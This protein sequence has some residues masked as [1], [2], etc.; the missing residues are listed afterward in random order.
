MRPTSI[1][2]FEGLSLLAVAI[3]ALTTWLGWESLVASVRSKVLGA[4]L[5]PALAVLSI[6]Y[7]GLLVLL[8]LLTARLGSA[9][10]KWLFVAIIVGEV[11]FTVPKL[12]AMAG[13]GLI[14]W[15]EIVQLLIQLAAVALLFT[16]LSRAWFAEWRAR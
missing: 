10:A 7:V 6:I 11:V 15:A 13:A 2:A 5:E 9:V 12:G 3:G 16:A 14:G 1:R 8:I 4:G